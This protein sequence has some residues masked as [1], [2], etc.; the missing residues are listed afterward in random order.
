MYIIYQDLL[1]TLLYF[2]Y[3][4]KP[5]YY[6]QFCVWVLNFSFQY[7][8]VCSIHIFLS[9]PEMTSN[10]MLILNNNN[11]NNNL[12]R[13]NTFKQVMQQVNITNVDF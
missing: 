6:A 3:I 11:N 13:W 12:K 4:Y 7:K 10:E 8:S 1:N 9:L 5:N 2:I